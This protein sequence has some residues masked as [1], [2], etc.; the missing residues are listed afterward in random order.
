MLFAM[1][2]TSLIRCFNYCTGAAHQ[3]V[4]SDIKQY[5]LHLQIMVVFWLLA[6][7]GLLGLYRPA[8]ALLLDLYTS[9]KLLQVKVLARRYVIRGCFQLSEINLSARRHITVQTTAAICTLIG[10]IRVLFRL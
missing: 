10:M 6:Y 5:Y 8:I 3:D 2:Y 9:D 7:F 1:N 4:T